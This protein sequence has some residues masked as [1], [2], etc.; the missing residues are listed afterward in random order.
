MDTAT[1]K[2]KRI[3]LLMEVMVTGKVTE[4]ATANQKSIIKENQ[5]IRINLHTD[6][7][8]QVDVASRMDVVFQVDVASRVD[9]VS[10][11]GVASE[12]VKNFRFP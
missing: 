12:G 4:R 5:A 10:Q 8:S 9:A 3:N 7:A 1:I 2:G 6:V 11:V